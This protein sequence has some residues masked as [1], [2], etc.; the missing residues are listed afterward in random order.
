M[1]SLISPMNGVMMSK[2]TTHGCCDA[3]RHREALEARVY[4]ATGRC[5]LNSTGLNS[6]YD[7]FQHH[8][9]SVNTDLI[10]DFS[11]TPRLSGDSGPVTK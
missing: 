2:Q 7:G 8:V 1:V 3:K 11:S 5:W 6:P 9:P 4:R 10:A